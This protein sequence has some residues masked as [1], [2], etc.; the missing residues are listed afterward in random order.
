MSSNQS[1]NHPQTQP[2]N[3]HQNQIITACLCPYRIECKSLTEHPNK[4]N[5]TY[6]QHMYFSLSL[7]KIFFT[8]CV[9]A[10]IHSFCPCFYE[11]SSSDCAE[12]ITKKIQN[13]SKI[14]EN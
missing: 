1:Q 14:E 7:S 12:K 3:K 6:F 9:K 11:T 10:V 4:N 8:G 13:H 5:M 2:Q